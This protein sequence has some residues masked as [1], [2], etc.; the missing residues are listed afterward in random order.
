MKILEKNPDDK[1]EDSKMREKGF[2][3]RLSAFEFNNYE[4]ESDDLQSKY[5]PN[6]I[7]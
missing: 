1:S 5:H 4:N 6:L 3:K 7:T 2:T